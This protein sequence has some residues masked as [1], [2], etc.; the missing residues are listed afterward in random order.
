LWCFSF[1]FK[2]GP[3][4]FLF[5][6]LLFGGELNSGHSNIGCIDT[7][8]NI[9]NVIQDAFENAR[10]LCEQY[11]LAAPDLVIKDAKGEGE[12]RMTDIN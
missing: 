8:C 5:L 4:F 11:Y 3:T 9:V 10:F 6:A 1:L 2:L 12:T 7:K